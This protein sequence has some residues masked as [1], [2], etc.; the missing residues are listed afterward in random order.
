MQ[1][2]GSFGQVLDS[3]LYLITNQVS[4]IAHGRAG[5]KY[6]CVLSPQPVLAMLG[7][8][9]RIRFSIWNGTVM[10]CCDG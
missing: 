4:G 1:V 5:A 6:R 8:P 10:E 3:I 7:D 9:D 2:L